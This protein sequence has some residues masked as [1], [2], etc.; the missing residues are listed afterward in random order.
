MDLL[1]TAA[2]PRRTSSMY[3]NLPHATLHFH[4]LLPDEHDRSSQL[5]SRDPIRSGPRSVASSGDYLDNCPQPEFCV[6]DQSV[7][8]VGP[9]VPA[10]HVTM[11]PAYGTHAEL[12]DRWY[13][14]RYFEL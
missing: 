2:N 14:H 3:L 12:R 10:E 6:H 4:E 7:N 11:Y 1:F 13:N 5:T 8:V 9:G